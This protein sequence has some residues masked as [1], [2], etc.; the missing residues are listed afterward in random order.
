MTGSSVF[1]FEADGKAEVIYND[2]LYMRVYKG[3][4]SGVDADGDGYFDAEILLEIPNSS[5]TLLEYPLVVDVDADGRAEILAVANELY[6]KGENGLRIFGDE[7]DNWVGTRRIWN[8]HSYHVTNICD[9]ID[10]VCLAAENQN[11]V[12]PEA[13]QKNWSLS[14]LNNY[15]QNVQGVGVFWVPDLVLLNQEAICESIK[16]VHISF[17]V[18]NQGS[19]MVPKGVVVS[20]YVNDVFRQ[21]VTTSNSLLP[22]QLER[23]S[24]SWTIPDEL[25][26]QLLEMSVVA[27]DLGEGKGRFNECNEG[28]NAQIF[29]SLVCSNE[30]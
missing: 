2:E 21:T 29:D 16:S 13:E 17:D 24:F 5:G 28:N 25:Q 14:W 27:D 9:G 6:S 23:I 10:P 3:S 1:D 12:V 19:R 26:N 30:Y 7:L 15:R 4:G 11:C 22:G 20:L 18:M 8:Q